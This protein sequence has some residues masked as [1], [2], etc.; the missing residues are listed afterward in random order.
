MEETHFYTKKQHLEFSFLEMTA[1]VRVAKL[2]AMADGRLDEAETKLM[3]LQAESFGISIEDYGRMLQI[4]D[5]MEPAFTMEI[6][7]SM[8]YQKKKYVAAYLG[9]IMMIDEDIDEKEFAVWNRITTM[10]GLPTMS[11][12]EAA[13]YIAEL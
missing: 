3:F 9:T 1:I 7:K 12:R 11:V 6:I 4:G 2:M 10:A 13:M 5:K 8:D